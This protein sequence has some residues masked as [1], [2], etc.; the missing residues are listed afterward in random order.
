MPQVAFVRS[1]PNRLRK[2]EGLLLTAWTTVVYIGKRSDAGST[3]W[4]DILGIGRQVAPAAV[5]HREMFGIRNSIAKNASSRQGELE[6]PIQD[7]ADEG[8]HRAIVFAAKRFIDL[9]V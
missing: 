5:T 4:T 8:G 6:N 1:E 9:S 7:I 3:T 2:A